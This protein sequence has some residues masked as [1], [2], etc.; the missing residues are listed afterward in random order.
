MR[1][2]GLLDGCL[3]E[4]LRRASPVELSRARLLAGA[5]VLLTVSGLLSL[6]R[7][8]LSDN[9]Y[10]RGS[11]VTSGVCLLGF[12]AALGLLR[13]RPSTRVPALL[14][15]SFIMLGALGA[16]YF[17]GEQSVATH[18]TVMLV[19]LLSVYLLGVRLG[20]LFSL[21]TALHVGLLHPLAFGYYSDESRWGSSF[22]AALFV[23]SA[24]LVSWLFT[25]ARDAAHSALEEALRT[26]RDR[27]GKLASV[28]EHTQDVVCSLDGHGRLL[29]MNPA[30]RR[31]YQ[32]LQGRELRQGEVLI[33]EGGTGLRGQWQALLAQV[34]SGRS[35]HTEV[36]LSDGA[37]PIVLDVSLEPILSPDG[38]VVGVT[39][40]GRDITARKEAEARLG[41]LHR[42]LLDVSRQAG[43]AEIATGVLHNVGNTLNSVNVSAGLVS[44]RLRAL[45]VSGVER[46]AGLLEEHARDLPAFFTS[47]P[48]GRQ[49]PGY[50]RALS[51]QLSGEQAAL[52]DEVRVLNE[53]VEHIK[54]VVSMQQ[55]HARTAGMVEP[56]TVPQLLDDALR[57]HAVSFERLGIQ[58]RTEY[59]VVPPVMVDRHKLLQIL[60]NLL[61]NARHALLDSG[62]P[63]KHITL[64]VACPSEQRLRI[65]VA[66][67]G[68]GVAPEHM[69]RM[70]SQGFT[71]KKA[72]HG[73][74][75]HIS[76]LAAEEMGGSLTCSSAGRGQGATFI[77]ELPMRAEESKA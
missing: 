21:L 39:M 28:L 29:T 45:R 54:A 60:L 64:R 18:A 56:V 44:E 71:T 34:L 59:G 40:F 42:N 61:S 32:R 23:V 72:G 65:E 35:A 22:F 53:N 26:L 43:M 63:D 73:F 20:M 70:F 48:R 27:E 69:S 58:L 1:L 5:V 46:A 14:L 74:G 6:V 12:L 47:D 57:L 76:A 2:V 49:L 25:A 50:L 55:A 31:L 68:I 3:S 13:W 15:C 62:R 51:G 41:E 17:R 66:D 77:I 8:L 37:Q 7:S 19:P 52:L 9:A 24:G 4:P 30:L 10:Q 36:S 16:A 67:N 11:A 75:L 38:G 33:P